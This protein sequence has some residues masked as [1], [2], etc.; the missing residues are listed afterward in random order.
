MKMEIQFEIGYSFRASAQHEELSRWDAGYY[1]AAHGYYS[2][3]K[4]CSQ[5]I[6]T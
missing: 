6:Q 4:M 2:R 3:L 5:T 1:S